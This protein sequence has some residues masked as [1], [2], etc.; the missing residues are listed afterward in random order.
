MSKELS[1]IA[2]ALMISVWKHQR[3]D[4]VIASEQIKTLDGLFDP[5]EG[6]SINTDEDLLML[7][8][9]FDEEE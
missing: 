2:A 6:A 1:F 5:W 8:D 4:K 9:V 7:S 3:E